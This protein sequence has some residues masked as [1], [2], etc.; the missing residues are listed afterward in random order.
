VSASLNASS[1]RTS[2]FATT[3]SRGSLL[4]IRILSA[5]AVLLILFIIFAPQQN[6]DSGTM[7]SSYAVGAGGT[8][9]L[10]DVLDRVGFTVSRN[11]RPL[12][13]A[14]A[15]DTGSVY[16]LLSPTQPLTAVELTHLLRSVRTGAILVLTLDDEALADSLGFDAST[17]SG[18]FYTLNRTDVAGGNPATASDQD[19][20]VLLQASFPI[21]VT[22]SSKLHERNDAFLWLRPPKRSKQA[23]L[24]SA[25]Q[26]ALVLGHRVGRGY[27]IAVAPSQII[28]NQIIRESR[29]AIAIVRGIEFA[30][31]ILRQPRSNKVVF[32][33]YHHG[34]GTHADMVAAVEHA[35]SGTPPGRVTIEIIVA[36]LILLLAFGVRPLAPVPA[37]PISRRSPLEHVGALAYAYSQ[38]DAR[39]LGANRLVRGLRRRHPLG[40]PRSLP[41]TAYLAALRDRI[42]RVSSDVDNILATLA[43]ESSRSQTSS[44]SFAETGAAVAN[45]ERAFRE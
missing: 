44:P 6:S 24:D 30:S 13:S 23:Q 45:I 35:L 43:I 16:V 42:P 37:T 10:Y 26:P 28:I 31:S 22:V 17:P 39:A 2:G 38:V 18:G 4:P 21:A 9:A 5:V 40:L 19:P 7:Y 14:A 34:F 36:A 12:T 11:E 41:D 25:Q 15:L 29:P 8:R 3:P 27:A 20:R 1:G 33:E 32:D